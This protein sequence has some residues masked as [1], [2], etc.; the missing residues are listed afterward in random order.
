MIAG[1]AITRA[2]NVPF[3]KIFSKEM[4]T[5]P[6][7]EFG[8]NSK[9][10]ILLWYKNHSE[11]LTIIIG[12]L[13]TI[14]G[15]SPQKSHIF[16]ISL[17]TLSIIFWI[18]FYWLTA[19][20]YETWSSLHTVRHDYTGLAITQTSMVNVTLTDRIIS[21][22]LKLLMVIQSFIKWML[23]KYVFNYVRVPG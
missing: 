8:F 16:L 23:K 14:I 9:C 15:N 3:I 5:S 7:S 20:Q 13:R 1:T 21:V 4:F 10:V 19:I 2:S 18:Y 22:I 12:Y 17:K 11:V 6:F